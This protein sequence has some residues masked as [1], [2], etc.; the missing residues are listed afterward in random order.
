MCFLLELHS[1]WSIVRRFFASEPLHLVGLPGRAV[2][3]IFV[4]ADFAS[5]FAVELTQHYYEGN[6]MQMTNSLLLVKQI[7][8]Q[9]L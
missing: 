5:L 9:A 3:F 4:I 2:S 1:L 6:Y 8:S 7:V